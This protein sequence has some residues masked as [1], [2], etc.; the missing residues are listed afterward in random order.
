MASNM[1]TSV[2]LSHLPFEVYDPSSRLVVYTAC[3][4]PE[5]V[6]FT[7]LSRYEHLS[8][9]PGAVPI[10][11]GSKKS[12]GDYLVTTLPSE[13]PP[14]S[15]W[16]HCFLLRPLKAFIMN[17][18]GFPTAPV[19]P[20]IV[21]HRVRSSPFGGMG[22]FATRSISQGDLILSERAL[23]IAPA[24]MP[25]T[26]KTAG[27]SADEEK[28]VILHSS[29][30]CLQNLADRMDADEKNAYMSLYNDHKL[31][32]S[33][34]LL[35]IMRTNGYCIDHLREEGGPL[36]TLSISSA[37]SNHPYSRREHGRVLR[38]ICPNV[39]HQS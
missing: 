30:K 34:P 15:A 21:S 14:G 20:S 35:G 23:I 3:H 29:D 33:G 7:E 4:L 28:R 22:M 32:G 6:H 27:L 17:T 38:R 37:T 10:D 8:W 24:A 18:P 13:R 39:S 11:S 16:T 25:C 2:R 12:N 9:H 19:N 1:Q 36:F 26:Y 31:D 5:L